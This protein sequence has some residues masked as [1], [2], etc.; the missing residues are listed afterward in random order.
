MKAVMDCV[1]VRRER[2]GRG[3]ERGLIADLD[4]GLVVL[5]RRAHTLEARFAASS[6]LGPSRRAVPRA[7]LLQLVVTDRRDDH[8]HRQVRVRAAQR[9]GC[10]E[11]YA[12]DLHGAV[13]GSRRLFP[14]RFAARSI[15][16]GIRIERVRTLLSA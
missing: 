15:A 1:D 2:Y 12:T 4:R 16:P 3:I 8:R 10:A 5:D 13:V 11:P 9:A 7:L 14:T 6:V